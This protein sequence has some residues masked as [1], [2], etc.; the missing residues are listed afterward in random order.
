M[1]AAAI[2]AIDDEVVARLQAVTG[3]GFRFAS[4]YAVLMRLCRWHRFNGEAVDETIGQLSSHFGWSRATITRALGC[5]E[6]AGLV[7][8]LTRG[9]GRNHRGSRRRLTFMAQLDAATAPSSTRQLGADAD[10]SSP[11]NSTL[12]GPNS[13][14]EGP[15]SHLL[16]RHSA[17]L[18]ARISARGDRRYVESREERVAPT[19]G[20][21]LQADPAPLNVN[22]GKAGVAAA[23]EAMRRQATTTDT[24][25]P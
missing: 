5:L 15:N 3:D 20:R 17:R 9:G 11:T 1:S 21:L 25:N 22:G 6:L 24:L 7:E 13:T 23:R 16:Q 8:T 18:S 12:E 10:A 4:S 14:L 2:E 19:V